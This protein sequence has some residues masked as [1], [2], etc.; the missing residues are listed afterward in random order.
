MVLPPPSRSE[1]TPDCAPSADPAAPPAPAVAAPSLVADLEA[2]LRPAW[3]DVDLGALEHNLRLMQRRL[4]AVRIMAM[5]KA[6]AYGHGA[7]GVSRALAA[8]GVDWLGVALLEEGAEI[9]RAGIELPILVLGTARPAKIALYRRYRL[10]PT[11]S[12]LAELAL[13]RDFAEAERGEGG[14]AQPI[15]L[16]VDT[17]MGRLGVALDEMGEALDLVRRDRRLRLAG[18]L[19]HFAEADDRLSPRNAQQEVRFAAVLSLLSPAERREALVH[20]ANSAAAL[21]RPASRYQLVRLGL[22]L[23]GLDPAAAPPPPRSDSSAKNTDA[24]PGVAIRSDALLPVMSVRAQIVQ[25]REVPAGAPLSYGGRTV[26]R[27]PSRIAVV[28]VGYA[29]GYGWRLTGRAEA[30][31]RGRRVPVAGTVT[32]DMTLLDVTETG[33]ELGDEVVLLGRQGSEEI[34]APELAR[35]AGTISW[36]ILCHLGLRLPRRYI[37]EGRVE[38]LVSRFSREDG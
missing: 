24:P 18:L 21:Y 9:R 12:S 5:V 25:L 34:S 28:P 2:A 23:Y 15:H 26:T 37:R 14:D 31:L 38:E 32:M 29:D 17:G 3:V 4:G 22:A 19:S 7:I 13:W 16:K 36:E 35:D 11:V 10:V 27:R 6:D 20:M 1:P 33:A 8:A 30:L